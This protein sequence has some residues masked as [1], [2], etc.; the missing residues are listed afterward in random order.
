[1]EDNCKKDTKL[2]F[3]YGQYGEEVAREKAHGGAVV[4]DGSTRTIYVDGTAFD[5]DEERKAQEIIDELRGGADPE[6][7]TFKEVEDVLIKH[8]EDI[9]ALIDAS[10][11]GNVAWTE[12]DASA[13]PSTL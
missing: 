2:N 1:M 8:G 7:D 10:T 6:Y 4:F 5:G 13:D 11:S 3:Y 9:Q 12:Y